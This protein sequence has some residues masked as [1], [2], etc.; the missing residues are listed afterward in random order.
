MSPEPKNNKK[1]QKAR[2]AV[3][4]SRITNSVIFQVTGTSNVETEAEPSVDRMD[5][6]RVVDEAESRQAPF[7]TWYSTAEINTK[8]NSRAGAFSARQTRRNKQQNREQAKGSA[9]IN[10]FFSRVQPFEVRPSSI[11]VDEQEVVEY[12]TQVS[13]AI[14]KLRVFLVPVINANSVQQEMGNYELAKY[15]S[16]YHYFTAMTNNRWK[17]DKATAYRTMKI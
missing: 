1:L 2:E 12:Q 14:G 16:V 7:L 5:I 10:S 3:R 17:K 6:D 9:D 13:V 15:D 8:K 11:T 4:N